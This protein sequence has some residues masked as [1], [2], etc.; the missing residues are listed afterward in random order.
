MELEIKEIEK[1]GEK[2]IIPEIAFFNY[3][4]THRVTRDYV[5]IKLIDDLEFAIFNANVDNL[6]KIQFAIYLGQ[7]KELID[8]FD[9]VIDLNENWLKK[10]PNEFYNNIIDTLKALIKAYFDL[11]K[12]IDFN[13]IKNFL[14]G[15]YSLLDDNVVMSIRNL[16]YEIGNCKI[17]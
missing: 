8:L 3:L 9:I 6:E 10:D 12:G 17:K 14:I 2:E 16:A 11:E 7:I 13:K 5:F 4:K 1:D 15:T